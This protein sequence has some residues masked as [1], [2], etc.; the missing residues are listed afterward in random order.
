MARVICQKTKPSEP[1]KQQRRFFQ[2]IQQKCLRPFRR[3]P[4]WHLQNTQFNY[5]PEGTAT[6]HASPTTAKKINRFFFQHLIDPK[7][8]I[9]CFGPRSLRRF[10]CHLQNT[11]NTYV[12][13]ETQLQ[14]QIQARKKDFPFFFNTS[15]TRNFGSIASA[16]GSAAVSS[17]TAKY[18]EY[19]CPEETH[20]DSIQARKRIFFY[21]STPH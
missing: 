11:Q 8:R 16:R 1:P 5:F 10:L 4:L 14:T 6:L 21:F 9:H 12:P 13:E 19:L 20:S 2:P 17:V 15:L 18:P 7:L 3:H